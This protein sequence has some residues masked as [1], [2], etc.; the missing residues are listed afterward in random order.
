M[1]VTISGSPSTRSHLLE[2][3]P[4]FQSLQRREIPIR[5]PYH[6]DHLYNQADVTRII[7]NDMARILEQYSVVHPV[8]G[9]SSPRSS[10]ST[11]E[12]FRQSVMEVLAR[13][14]QWDALVRTCV[15]DVRLSAVKGVRVLAMGP[16][17]L[18][19]S[20]V[21][22]LKAGGGLTI[23]LEDGV[24]WFAQNPLPRV[25]GDLKNAK[26]AIVGMAGRFPNAADHETFWKLLEQGLD[27]HREV[28]TQRF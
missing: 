18:T 11:L 15:A 12:I 20:L 24:S 28:S 25:N 4:A 1:S 27:V 5:G 7:D 22:A 13:Q 3:S 21:S 26:I 6:A 19:N 16:T 10:N 8:I 2:T 9:L 23:A 14:V 17:A